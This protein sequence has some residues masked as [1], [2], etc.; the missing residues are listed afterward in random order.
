MERWNKAAK[1]VGELALREALSCG[2][3]YIGPEHI[4]KALDRYEEQKDATHD[5][6]VRACP[7]AAPAWS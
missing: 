5:K 1:R 4:R 3:N 6:A 7:V 2:H